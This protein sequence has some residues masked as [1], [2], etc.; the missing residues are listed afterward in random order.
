[1]SDSKRIQI[2]NAFRTKLQNIKVED[3]YNFTPDKVYRDFIPY[4]VV[5]LSYDPVI[6]LLPGESLYHPLTSE[7]YTSGSS[8]NDI[9]GWFI[10]VIG[11]VQAHNEEDDLINEMEKLIQDILTAMLTDHRIGLST[12]VANVHLRSI[13]PHFPSDQDTKGIVQCIFTCKYDFNK[14]SP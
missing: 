7:E 10:S 8:S 14:S 2:L 5:S 11:Y 4:E 3:G 6:C 1:M 12:F 13:M 9:D